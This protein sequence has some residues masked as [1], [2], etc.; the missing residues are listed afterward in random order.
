MSELFFL[1]KLCKYF[2]IRELFYREERLDGELFAAIW[3][4]MGIFTTTWDTTRA[5]NLH[6]HHEWK[7]MGKSVFLCHLFR[8]RI[9][10]CTYMK[11]V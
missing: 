8:I 5:Q 11:C 1:F 6:K 7:F 2:E 3:I 4:Q 10:M 9:F